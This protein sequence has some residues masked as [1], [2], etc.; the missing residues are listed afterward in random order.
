MHHEVNSKK[1]VIFFH[2]GPQIV[3]DYFLHNDTNEN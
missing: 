2:P 3:P 1:E